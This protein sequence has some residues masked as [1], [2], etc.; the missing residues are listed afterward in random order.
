MKDPALIFR[1]F[2]TDGPAASFAPVKS[3]HINETW[4]VTTRSG[5]RYILQ[6]IN[7]HVFDNV[8]A[9]MR[10]AARIGAYLRQAEGAVPTICYLETAD[11]GN[12][13]EDGEGGAWR[14]YPF[15]EHSVCHLRA[16]TLE[17]VA[18]SG[19]GFGAFL[20]ALRNFPAGELEETI[21]DFHH[22]PR[23]FESFRR[24][25]EADA[26][27]R[28]DRVRTETA[29]LLERESRAG[30]LQRLR[31][32]G[33]LPLR[34]THNDTKIS[35]VLMH[36]DTGR[37]LCVIDLDTVMP[38][39]AAYDYGDA[40]RSCGAAAAEDETE[41]G[42]QRLDL[43][44]CRAFTRGFLESCPEL[45]AAELRSLPLGA[46]IMTLECGLRFLTDYL[47]G[48]RYFSIDYSAHNLDRCR[49]QL[50]LLREM[51][52]HWE[53]LERIVEEEKAPEF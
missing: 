35:N 17:Q 43:A 36:A 46:W 10:N 23:R 32:T 38:G 13:L 26:C 25:L 18:E 45:T 34:V 24:A 19:R 14:C 22:T 27:G 53:D 7:R 30:T 51:E 5:A 39:L 49:A 4:L 20:H 40:I 33:E 3:G 11:G 42:K 16:E 21:A 1:R 6:R 41:P 37:A 31:E 12:W 48:D 29:F 2:Q 9:V 52:E 15:V 28:R 44:R 50:M 47:L 8:D